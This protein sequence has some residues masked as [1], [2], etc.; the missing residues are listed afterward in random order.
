MD[1]QNNINTIRVETHDDNSLI[2]E[3]E[4]SIVEADFVF[5]SLSD[6]ARFSKKLESER[7]KMIQ[8]R[9]LLLNDLCVDERLKYIKKLNTLPSFIEVPHAKNGKVNNITSKI[10][11]KLFKSNGKMRKRS[12]DLYT[13]KE[14][15]IHQQMRLKS[16][17]K[18][19]FNST[20][21]KSIVRSN[22]LNN[23]KI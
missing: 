20:S 8:D 11:H 7:S 3:L 23:R 18:K 15:H 10:R 9:A 14:Y 12:P 13:K 4:D 22:N 16:E 21:R 17:K 5:S 1:Y 19:R 6:K 2:K